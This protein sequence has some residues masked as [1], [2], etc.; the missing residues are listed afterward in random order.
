LLSIKLS[1]LHN[2]PF[3]SI[4]PLK[5]QA[6]PKPK[7]KGIWD[8]FG[9]AGEA[10][11]DDYVMDGDYDPLPVVKG[12]KFVGIVGNQ[13]HTL[14]LT[15]CVMTLFQYVNCHYANR[16]CAFDMHIHEEI[17]DL[18][19]ILR[20]LPRVVTYFIWIVD[21]MLIDRM[22]EAENRVRDSTILY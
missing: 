10:V 5:S 7:K 18:G 17:C 14:A 20:H 3:L 15:Q 19:L 16:E 21:K 11:I 8:S 6:P 2:Y 4:R 13:R 12:I 9:T 22:D 1:S